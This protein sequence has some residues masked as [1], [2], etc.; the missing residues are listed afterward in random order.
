MPTT[1]A[2][3]PIML[4]VLS[5][6]RVSRGPN[7]LRELD[8][9]GRAG[10]RGQAVG[11]V[12]ADADPVGHLQQPQPLQAWAVVED[13]AHA[14]WCADGKNRVGAAGRIVVD[15][16]RTAGL[17]DSHVGPDP[18]AADRDRLGTAGP[19]RV[20]DELQVAVEDDLPAA[21]HPLLGDVGKVWAGTG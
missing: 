15:E 2:A 4:A 8:T 17:P 13:V 16:D 14:V 6:I 18:G 11:H 9:P 10:R 21:V 1:S 5:A 19:Q 12:H 20:D 7:L 3:I